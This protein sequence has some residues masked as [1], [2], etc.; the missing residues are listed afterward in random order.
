M[1]V[2]VAVEQLGPVGEARARVVAE[3]V[4]ADGSSPRPGPVDHQQPD[5]GQRVAERADLPVEHR[6]D[7]AVVADHA[8]V[9]P[10]V[11]VDDAGRALLGDARPA[12]GRGPRRPPGSSRVLR[13]LPLAVPTPELAGDVALVAAEVAQPDGVEVDGVDGGQGVDERLAGR[14]RVRSR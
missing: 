8:V 12:G 11:A 10:V 2:G 14:R 1:T 5:V 7:V 6:D 4:H 9:E 3:P 13:L